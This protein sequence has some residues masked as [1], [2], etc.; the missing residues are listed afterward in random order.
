MTNPQQPYLPPVPL[1]P[2]AV[3]EDESEFGVPRGHQERLAR[4]AIGTND[5]GPYRP[6]A[7]GKAR[8]AGR[9]TGNPG[10]RLRG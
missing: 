8:F 6:M 2:W 3:N 5:G 9:Q 10:K 7:P 1:D 4:K